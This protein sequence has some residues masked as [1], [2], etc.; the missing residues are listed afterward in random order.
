V[1]V[2][3]RVAQPGHSG[4]KREPIQ[5]RRNFL[6]TNADPCVTGERWLLTT[7]C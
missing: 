1:G 6:G 4:R 7:D 3:G 5:R 2:H